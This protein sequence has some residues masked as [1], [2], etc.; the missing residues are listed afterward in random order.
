MQETGVA[1]DGSATAICIEAMAEYLKASDE[2]KPDTTV[3]VWLDGKK[4]KD[5]KIDS[6][7]LFSFDGTLVLTGD[8]VETGQHKLEIRK[9]GM[10]PVY[11]NAYVTNFTL[12]DFITKAG[13]GYPVHPANQVGNGLAPS[14]AE[15]A[16][17]LE[18]AL[19]PFFAQS[20]RPAAAPGPPR[21]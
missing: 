16:G 21:H 7:N 3:E 6:T 19:D 8:A 1:G 5:A 12:E 10:G 9:K 20:R 2:D 13:L 15:K 14:G 4:H 11:F 17:S 18:V